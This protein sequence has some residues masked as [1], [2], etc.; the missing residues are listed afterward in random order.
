[1]CLHGL[2][3]DSFTMWEPRHL[4]TL[5]AFTACY[6]DSFTFYL[7]LL[8]CRIWG[9]HSGRSSIFW[10]ITR[11]SPLEV[12]RNEGTSRSLLVT[13]FHAG[14]LLGLFFDPEDGSNMFLWNVG[15]LSTDYMALYSKRC[16]FSILIFY[17]F[18][19]IAIGLVTAMST[20]QHFWKHFKSSIHQ[21]RC[22]LCIFLPSLLQLS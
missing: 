12:N 8:L 11:C 15:L 20:A 22:I 14:L 3:Q 10:D 6:R 2:L 19:S 1:M 9:S 4:T 18:M 7:L 16:N 17:V 13:W 5:W 21:I